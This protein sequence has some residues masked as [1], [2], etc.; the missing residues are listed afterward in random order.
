M[1]SDWRFPRT[2]LNS[3]AEMSSTSDRD[4]PERASESLLSAEVCPLRCADSVESDNGST[5]A[6][7][8]IAAA[9]RACCSPA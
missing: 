4:C 7:V 3:S 1:R 8:S 9:L 2:N 5:A 6:D